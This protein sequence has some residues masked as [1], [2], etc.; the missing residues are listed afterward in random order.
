MSPRLAQAGMQQQEVVVEDPLRGNVRVGSTEIM[1]AIKKAGVSMGHDGIADLRSLPVVNEQLT[2]LQNG[3]LLFRGD[4]FPGQQLEWRVAQ[5]DEGRNKSGG[6]ERSWAT[7]VTVTLPNL[8][9]VTALLKLDGSAVAV[10][11]TA[12]ND[13][14]VPVLESGL[15][16]LIEQMEGAGLSPA[17]MS[18]THAAA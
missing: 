4:I 8:G 15:A 3:Q 5:K 11:I 1:A 14:A 16:R 7:S 13:G 9:P 2:A 6:R 10:T 18:I 17:E 12:E